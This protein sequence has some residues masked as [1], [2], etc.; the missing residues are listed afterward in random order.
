MISYYKAIFYFWLS[1]LFKKEHECRFRQGDVM[2]LK[3]NPRCTV[4]N[5]PLESK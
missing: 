2:N 5:K 3:I 4:C 1:D